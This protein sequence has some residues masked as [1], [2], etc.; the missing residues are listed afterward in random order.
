MNHNLWN[1]SIVLCTF[2][3]IGHKMLYWLVVEG[4]FRVM[5]NGLYFIVIAFLVAKS[6]KVLIYTNSMICDLTMWA[7]HYFKWKEG[8]HFSSPL[9]KQNCL[10]DF[11][12]IWSSTDVAYECLRDSF[13][14]KQALLHH[15][16]IITKKDK[17]KCFCSFRAANNG[18]S[19][20]NV[21]SKIGFVW[22]SP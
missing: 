6:F 19:M 13:E 10:P 11:H 15:M 7:H 18:Q 22:S 8:L 2:K 1:A 17:G 9:S 5:K 20:D 4:A 21:R 14:E 3:C 16:Q 12:M